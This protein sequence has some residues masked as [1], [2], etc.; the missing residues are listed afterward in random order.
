MVSSLFYYPTVLIYTDRNMFA[1]TL[2]TN[3][4]QECQ[5]NRAKCRQKRARRL[6]EIVMSE[7][8]DLELWSREKANQNPT[9]EPKT[10]LQHHHQDLSKLSSKSKGLNSQGWNRGDGES[11]DLMFANLQSWLEAVDREDSCWA[12][13]SRSCSTSQ[14]S[15]SCASEPCSPVLMGGKTQHRRDRSLSNMDLHSF[16]VFSLPASV[17][18]PF[19]SHQSQTSCSSSPSSPNSLSPSTH[20]VSSPAGVVSP[21]RLFSSDHLPSREQLHKEEGVRVEGLQEVAYSPLSSICKAT[22]IDDWFCPDL[23]F[24]AGQEEFAALFTHAQQQQQQQCSGSRVLS[25]VTA[26]AQQ[27]HAQLRADCLSSRTLLAG[28]QKKTL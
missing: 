22:D 9:I 18:P 3:N 5:S 24:Q 1:F 16:V 14:S 20:A 17:S 8:R 19:P 28:M 12:E 26:A 21:Q 15:T 4:P 23:K 10:P 6:V 13:Y 25:D 11:S 27:Q 7:Q 2:K